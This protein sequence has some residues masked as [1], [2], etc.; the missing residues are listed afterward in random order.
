VEESHT[1]A[2][3]VVEMRSVLDDGTRVLFRPIAGDDK[4]RLQSGLQRLSPRSR[5]MRFFRH[6]DRLSD[7]QLRYLTDVDMQDHVAWVA[8]LPDLDGQ[9]G[10]GVARWIRMR[11]EPEVAEAAV[12]V[13]DEF[14]DKGIGST[15]LFLAARS[16][17]ERGIR[18]FR[19]YVMGDN[20]KVMDLLE[21]LNAVPGA[22]EGGVLQMTIPLPE[23]MEELERSAPHLI[24]R[25]AARGDLDEPG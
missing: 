4:D 7:E 21:S 5:Y 24:L 23:T 6:L 19:L 10:V 1:P 22:W 14:Q 18:A 16:A 9:P 8:V 25:A 2:N 13:I 3:D 20:R 12:T 15:L 17:L 11:H